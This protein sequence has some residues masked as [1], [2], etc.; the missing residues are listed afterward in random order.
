MPVARVDA[1]VTGLGVDG[2]AVVVVADTGSGSSRF[3]VPD[4]VLRLSDLTAASLPAI[5]DMVTVSL[6]WIGRP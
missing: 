1:V 4:A 3:V 2:E 6:D 5:G